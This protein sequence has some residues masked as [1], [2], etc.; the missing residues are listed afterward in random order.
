MRNKYI[1]VD[2]D[3]V[4]LR[5]PEHDE[6][7]RYGVC[8]ALIFDY[9]E[10]YVFRGQCGTDACPFYKRREIKAKQNRDPGNWVS[11]MR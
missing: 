11:C 7:D 9:F 10:Q 8:D 4:C 6:K 3:C 5:R 1:R 2:S